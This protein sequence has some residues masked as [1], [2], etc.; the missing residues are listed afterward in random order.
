MIAATVRF[1]EHELG[2]LTVVLGLECFLLIED[3][4]EMLIELD[5]PGCV[6]ALSVRLDECVPG[7]GGIVVGLTSCGDLCVIMVIADSQLSDARLATTRDG[8]RVA[9]Q[10]S[11]LGDPRRGV[12][13][14]A[15]R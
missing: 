4:N 1:R 14:R 6:G 11:G 3:C 5:C 13:T 15:D 7:R 8:L 12:R 9:Y 10:R 2:L